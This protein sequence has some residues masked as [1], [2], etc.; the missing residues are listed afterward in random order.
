MINEKRIKHIQKIIILIGTIIIIKNKIYTS[1]YCILK[2]KYKLFKLF[3]SL[4][5]LKLIIT[6]FLF[7]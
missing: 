1:I 2:F 6:T 7:F 5:L 4:K 3:L